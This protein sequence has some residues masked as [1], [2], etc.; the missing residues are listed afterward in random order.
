ME[1]MGGRDNALMPPFPSEPHLLYPS[2]RLALVQG[3]EDDI[4]SNR[5]GSGFTCIVSDHISSLSLFR[6]PGTFWR[7]QKMEN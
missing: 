5:S 3:D 7:V 1:C 4:V 6:H 2:K